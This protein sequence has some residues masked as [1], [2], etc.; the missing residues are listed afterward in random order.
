MRNADV[1]RLFDEYGDLLEIQGSNPFRVRA[2]RNAARTIESLS[3]SIAS[4]GEGGRDALT[5]LPGIGDDLADKIL[6]VLDSDT[7]PQ[8]EEAREKIPPDVRRML[9]LPGI[10]PKKVAV[11]WKE[12]NVNSL[13]DLRAAAE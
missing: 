2:Y 6:A 8:L 13:D 11:L 10:G 7:F 1:A 4:V 9:D 3:D 12:L 5:E